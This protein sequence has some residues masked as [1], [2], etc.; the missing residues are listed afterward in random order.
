MAIDLNRGPERVEVNAK[1]IGAILVQGASTARTCLVIATSKADAPLNTPTPV[2]TPTQFEQLFGTQADMGEAYLSMVGFYAN[3][4][5]GAELVVIAVEPTGVSGEILESA[6][7]ESP[8][9]ISGTFGKLT[10]D[11]L[12]VVEAEIV[13]YTMATGELELDLTGATV[14]E[15]P[16]KG[17]FVRDASGRMFPITAVKP[18]NIFVI[19]AGLDRE[20]QKTSNSLSADATLV[21]IV[22]LYAEDEFASK[23]VVQKGAV[24]GAGVTVT[25]SG[26]IVSLPSFDAYLNDVR[27]G[28]VIVDSASASYIVLSV[29]D[30]DKIEVDRTGMTAGLVSI[31]RGLKNKVIQSTKEAGDTKLTLAVAPYE[32]MSGSVKFSLAD[33]EDNAPEGSLK[34]D[35]LKFDDVTLEISD[36][37]IVA[38]STIITSP[39]AGVLAYV[40]STGVATLTGAT[41]IT[42]GAK[43]G[44]VLIDA[45]GREYV[46]QEVLTET[47]VRLKK[48]QASPSSLAGAKIHKGAMEILLVDSVDL[49]EKTEGQAEEDASGEIA[50]KA[51]SLLFRQTANM[52]SEEYFIVTPEVTSSDFIGSE[53]NLTGLRALD[54]VDT[55]N[56][57]AIP[58]IYDPAVQGSL[59]DYCSVIR[60]DCMALVSIPEFVTSASID[61]LIASN[62]AILAVQESSNGSI[63]SLTGT[64]DLSEVSVYDILRIGSSQF[65][66]KAVSDEDKKIVVFQTTGIP[67]VGAISVV[68]PSAVSWKDVIINKPTTKVAWY[69]NHLLARDSSGTLQVVDPVGHVA[70]VMARIDQNISEGGVSRAPAGITLAQ[71]A[72]VEGLQLD[73]SERLD[74]GPLRLAFINR[75]TSSTGNGRY[76]FGAYTGAGSSAT[77][78][79]QLV[80]VIRSI[81]FVKSSLEAGL[82]GFLWQN[83]SPVTRQNIQNAIVN[84]LRA[85]AYLFPAGLPEA[86]Q[87]RVESITPDDLALAQGLVEVR[88]QVRFNTAIRFVSIDLA[89]P[90]PVSE[91]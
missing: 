85:N 36:N 25:V 49:T 56:L 82:V 40:A 37:K 58:G 65:I 5:E 77:P 24:Y 20:A 83:N 60:Q 12:V 41:V 62:L 68:S 48:N 23:L 11:G 29:L 75:I 15:A 26:K 64:P 7:A 84:F 79:E 21:S 35:F 78:D 10:D 18:N 28:D 44:D 86:Q 3:A 45:S 2:T 13:S 46:I 67:T 31:H 22:R 17:D 87:F 71:L 57:V 16:Q 89:F 39:I 14:A 32:A 30:G 27:S 59:I 70:G 73:I 54:S 50:H 72:G 9:T 88:V 42:D 69:Y 74:G 6:Q 53:A 52:K 55:I 38:E 63:I 66:I 76:V 81:L 8:R 47:T 19:Q 51:N 33:S 91:A 43:A 34:G 4:G 1:P 90:L 61:K 80:Q